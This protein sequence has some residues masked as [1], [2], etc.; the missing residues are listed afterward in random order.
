VLVIDDD[1][2]LGTAPA[3]NA[4]NLTF[5]GGTLST[6]EADLSF[7]GTRSFNLMLVVAR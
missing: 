4:V 3:S 6:T 1:N 5:N 2:K 7:S